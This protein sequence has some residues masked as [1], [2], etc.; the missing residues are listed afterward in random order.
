M[1]PAERPEGKHPRPE[2]PASQATA[3]AHAALLTS[4][5][6][7]AVNAEVERAE[8][9]T[10]VEIVVVVAL[11][12]S[13]YPQI[14]WKAFALG[15]ALAALTLVAASVLAPQWPAAD[16]TL[17]DAVTILGAGAVAA[18]ATVLVPAFARLFL[19]PPRAEFEARRAA[20]LM[21]HR[22]RVHLTRARNGALLHA[23]LFER[24]L[25]VV[26]DD[27]FAGRVTADEWRAA[28]GSVPPPGTRAQAA[29]ALV[30]GVRAIA[31]LL[32]QKGFVAANSDVNELPDRPREERGP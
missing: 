25:D 16:R 2:R 1:S 24:R 10:G 23:C 27:G 30:G 28:L 6:A 15:A 29:A 18:L 17:R 21:F 8:R 31:A 14:P 13:Q 11:R 12:A 5:E 4:A 7:D 22:H 20:E 26:A 3:R 32:A 9:S 19:R